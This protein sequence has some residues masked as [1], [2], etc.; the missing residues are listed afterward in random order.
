MA[1]ALAGTP[2][3]DYQTMSGGQPATGL[4]TAFN[5][6]LK[7]VAGP[8]GAG[9]NT[10]ATFDTIIGQVI[11][12]VLGLLGVIFLILAIYGG[13]NWMLARGNEEMVETAKK[14]ITNAVIGL[15]VV[16]AAYAISW[17]VINAIGGATLK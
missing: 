17:F 16:L 2:E 13:Y 12:M 10:T 11:T 9:F 15:I 14:T 1:P 6:P 3:E 4:G 8:G 7:T 5:E